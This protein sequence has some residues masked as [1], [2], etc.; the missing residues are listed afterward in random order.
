[1]C[2]REMEARLKV[3][4]DN[5]KNKKGKNNEHYKGG[6]CYECYQSSG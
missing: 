1:M 5:H 4:A 6:N 3:D 2:A